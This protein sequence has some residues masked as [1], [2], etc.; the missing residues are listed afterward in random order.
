[1]ST[2]RSASTS[3][4]PYGSAVSFMLTFL[5]DLSKDLLFLGEEASASRTLVNSRPSLFEIESPANRGVLILSPLN[6]SYDVF[7]LY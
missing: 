7:V 5:D 3:G 6:M 2:E 4:G 1:M